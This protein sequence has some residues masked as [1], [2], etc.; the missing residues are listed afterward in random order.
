MSKEKE[1][2]FVD[3]ALTNVPAEI[4]SKVKAAAKAEHVPMRLWII[5]AMKRK[6]ESAGQ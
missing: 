5:D 2:K 3:F 6:I 1:K 4:H